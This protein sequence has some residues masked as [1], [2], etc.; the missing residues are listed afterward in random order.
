MDINIVF[1][2][3]ISLAL[4]LLIV[5]LIKKKSVKRFLESNQEVP[6]LYLQKAIENKVRKITQALREGIA[7][8]DAAN[9]SAEA[10]YK[11]I[12]AELHQLKEQYKQKQISAKAYDRQLE[13]LLERI[14]Y[15][16][17]EEDED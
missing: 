8:G 13:E 15:L 12:G 2:A 14:E 4:L 3:L 11:E 1:G 10:E 9:S 16:Q 7:V 6:Q 5:S 17:D